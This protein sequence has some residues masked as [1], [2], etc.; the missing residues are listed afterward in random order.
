MMR[1]EGKVALVT[2]GTRSIGR[3]ISLALAREGAKVAMRI[4][5]IMRV[6]RI[7]SRKKSRKQR[8]NWIRH[9][10]CGFNRTVGHSHYRPR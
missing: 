10:R 7:G 6:L 4:M 8:R 3:G 2:G 9:A 5:R 1:I